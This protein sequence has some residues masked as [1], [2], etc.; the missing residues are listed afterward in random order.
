MLF[1]GTPRNFNGGE[2]ANEYFLEFTV[3]CSSALRA[4]NR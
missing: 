3:G 1:V 2:N 4:G